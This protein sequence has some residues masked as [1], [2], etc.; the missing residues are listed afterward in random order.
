MAL[1]LGPCRPEKVNREVWRL[2]TTVG[3]DGCD[4]EGTDGGAADG[5]LD[6][7]TRAAD[8]LWICGVVSASCTSPPL[9]ARWSWAVPAASNLRDIQ[10]RQL[11]PPPPLPPQIEG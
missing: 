5:K 10:I 6:P 8:V 11:V 2:R 4:D 3:E 7:A 9:T 1:F